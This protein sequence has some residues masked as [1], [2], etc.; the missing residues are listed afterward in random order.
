[1]ET[2]GSIM[3]HL[4]LPGYSSATRE[5]KEMPG[6]LPERARRRWSASPSCC[7]C[8][9]RGPQAPTKAQQTSEQVADPSLAQRE[10]P[11]A[12]CFSSL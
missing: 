7:V 6:C 9:E 4:E 12:R 5:R 10:A 2:L 8:K 1:M 11:G 3:K